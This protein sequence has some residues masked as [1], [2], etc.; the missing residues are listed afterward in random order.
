VNTIKTEKEIYDRIERIKS[1]LY[2]DGIEE[3][4]NNF[5]RIQLL[6]WVL[7]DYLVVKQLLNDREK[8]ITESECIN[9]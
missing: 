7:D 4:I 9:E 5:K 8:R 2:D 6:C 1:T 3:G